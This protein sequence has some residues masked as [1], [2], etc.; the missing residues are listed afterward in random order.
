LENKN[1]VLA[2]CQQVLDPQVQG[3]VL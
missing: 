2:T 1:K 3:Q